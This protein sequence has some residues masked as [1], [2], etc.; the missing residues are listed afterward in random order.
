M[1]EL[2]YENRKPQGTARSERERSVPKETVSRT[3]ISLTYARISACQ[4]V[5]YRIFLSKML[6]SI[7]KISV[8]GLLTVTYTF[9]DLEFR[10]TI[11]NCYP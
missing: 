8:S 6:T 11:N 9:R 5:S 7:T 3:T 2:A 1:T 4:I 10:I